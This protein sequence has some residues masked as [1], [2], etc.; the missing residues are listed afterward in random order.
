[1]FKL[2]KGACNKLKI[3]LNNNEFD[4]TKSINEIIFRRVDEVLINKLR[5]IEGSIS[6]LNS[7]RLNLLVL[8]ANIGE[9]TTI[10]DLVCKI[11]T[12]QAL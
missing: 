8:I 10:F 12:F 5:L 1:M 2:K 9:F 4:I 3:V 7:N 11:K 6:Y